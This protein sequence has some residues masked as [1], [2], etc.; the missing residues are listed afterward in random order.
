MMYWVLRWHFEIQDAEQVSRHGSAIG[1]S[2]NLRVRIG[3]ISI[4]ARGG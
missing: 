3:T 1:P 2:Y 4:V